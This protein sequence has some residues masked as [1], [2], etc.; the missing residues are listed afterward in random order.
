MTPALAVSWEDSKKASLLALAVALI[1]SPSLA[2]AAA[3]DAGGSRASARVSVIVR[4]QSGAGT[5]PEDVVRRLGGTIETRLPIIDGFVS[6]IPRRAIDRVRR[7]PGVLSISMNRRVELYGDDFNPITDPGSLRN[8]ARAIGADDYYADGIKGAGVDVAIIDS[9]VVPVEGLDVNGR[10]INGPDLS[11]ESQDPELRYLDAFGHGTHMAGI[12]AGHKPAQSSKRDGRGGPGFSGIAPQARLVSIKVADAIGATDVSQVIAAIDWVVQHRND[13]GM[14][15]RVLNLSFGTDG[16]QNPEIDPLSHAVEVAWDQG[17][18][19]V[20]AAGNR[21]FGSPKLNNPAINP[22]VIAVGAADTKGTPDVSDDTIPEFS[23]RGDHE[24][25]PDLLAPGKSIVSLRNPGS[26]VDVTFP[27]GAVSSHLF[28]GTGTSQAAAVVSGAAA[29]IVQQRP[30]IDPDGLKAL[31]MTTA[32]P[33]PA[34][35]PGQGTGLI[36]LAAA[37]TAPTPSTAGPEPPSPDGGTPSD[38]GPVVPAPETPDSEPA[39]SDPSSEE[40]PP[41]DPDTGDSAGSEE[42]PGADPLALAPGS[43]SLEL[44]RGTGHLQSPDG[45]A[46]IGEVDIF[47]V[48]WDGGAW[49]AGARTAVNWSGGVWS[50]S[51]WAGSLWEQSPWALTSW[52]GTIWARNSWS[53]A[54]WSRES[55]SR[56]SWSNGSWHGDAWAR[57]SWSGDGWARNSWSSHAWR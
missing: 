21:G 56:N 53:G 46:L 27:G 35:D 19:V 13:N 33:L 15:I 4:E 3:P 45:T 29:L 54:P 47:G 7:S 57:N 28:R 41:E 5:E 48:P 1:A 18:V 20:V 26:F 44:A 8:T 38:D 23:S 39:P 49:A 34:Q 55:W 36:N 14:N 2:P 24:R 43:G 6:D 40:T 12:I 11:L 16:T 37:K 17:I 31:L 25:R 42:P 22:S 52:Q 9:G 10:L 51:R 30:D 50:G 32:S